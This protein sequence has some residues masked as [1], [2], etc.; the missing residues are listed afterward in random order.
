MDI[1]RQF[2]PQTILLWKKVAEHTEAQRIVKLFPSAEVRLVKQQRYHPSADTPASQALLDSKRTL[3][4]GR[5]SSFVGHF[6]GR[7]GPNVFCRPYYKLVPVSNG[8]PFYCTYCYLAFVYRKHAPFIKININYETMFRQIRRAV[9]GPGGTASFNLG[10][11]LDSLA[12]DHVTNL[13]TRLVPFFSE[14]SNA[15]LMLLTKSNNTANLLQLKPNRQTVV[16]WS[17]NTQQMIDTHEIGAASLS[18]RIQAAKA[19]QDHGYRIRLR[20]DPGMLHK[21]WRAAYADLI[22]QV[23]TT[24]RPENITLGMLRLLPGHLRLAE[25]AYGRRARKLHGSNLVKGASDGKLRY[26]PSQ[27]IEFYTFLADT[28]RSFDRNVSIGLC[29]ETPNI[30]RNLRQL[31]NPRECNCVMW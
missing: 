6:D 14:F 21:E 19:C 5:T 20:I 24:I 12:L 18:Q 2:K 15:Y 10:E 11:M 23:M 22:R 17:I 3:M 28:I 27:R 8:C 7:L 1:S 26:P 13:T 9:P 31:C 29:R 4:V 30:W 16:S 25:A